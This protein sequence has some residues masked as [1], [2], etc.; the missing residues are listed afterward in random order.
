[1]SEKKAVHLRF[2]TPQDHA[3]LVVEANEA[4]RSLNA[5]ILYLLRT[6]PER[7]KAKGKRK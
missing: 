3:A 6:H 2:D 7:K 4:G 5:H 1:M